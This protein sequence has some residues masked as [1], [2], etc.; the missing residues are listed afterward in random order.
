MKRRGILCFNLSRQYGDERWGFILLKEVAA[1]GLHG[2]AMAER[3]GSPEWG[4]ASATV[5]G[6]QRF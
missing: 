5:Y 6:F 2:G 3:D 1:L 4:L